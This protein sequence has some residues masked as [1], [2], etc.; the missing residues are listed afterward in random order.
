MAMATVL[1]TGANRGIGLALT[2]AFQGRGDHVIATC[3]HSSPE[4][5]GLLDRPGIEV[6]D[7]VDV[8]SDAATAALP[9][10]IG[11]DRR[12]D[13]LVLNAG[14]LRDDG[15]RIGPE[16]DLAQVAEQ[17]A[18]NAIAPLRVI[19]DLTLHLQAGSKIALI[20]SRMGSIADNTSGGYYGYRMSKAAMN[21]MG[22]SLARDLQA[23]RIAVA[24]LHP[25][26][27]RTAMVGYAGNVSAADS[28]Q[29]LLARIDALT[30]ETSGSFWHANGERL[31]W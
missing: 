13:V 3:R 30:L 9:G 17:L 15:G 31:P 29:M 24:L 22:M 20:T 23:R 21:A 1:I 25:G 19:R 2:R 6:V 14:I 5:E 7:G 10:R 28:A 26:F 4:L 8:T 12:I 11:L 16:L 27:V 18:V